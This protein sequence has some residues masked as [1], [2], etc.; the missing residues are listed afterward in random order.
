M[1]RYN[2]PFDGNKYVLNTN[3]GEVHDLDK[4]T[5]FCRIDEIKPKHIYA[6]DSYETAQL[7][8]F[9]C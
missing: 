5:V 4:E 3:T 1:R 8:A 9:F 7:H 2:L 6:C